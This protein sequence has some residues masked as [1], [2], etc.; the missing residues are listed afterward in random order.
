ML[1]AI[2]K[3]SAILGMAMG[4]SM[5]T[6]VEPAHAA[7]SKQSCGGLNQKTCI[8]VNPAKWCDAGL[9][10]LPKVGRDICIKPPPKPK[11]KP[12]D[13][14]GGLNQK[15]CINVNPAKWCNA[16]LVALPKLGR[17]ICG[18]APDK[19]P[20][21]AID[22]GCLLQ[23][24]CFSLNPAKWCDAGLTQLA[25]SGRNICIRKADLNPGS[26]KCGGLNQVRCE[27][28]NPAE[29]CDAGLKNKVV[30][31]QRDICVAANMRDGVACGGEGQI[32]CKN[33]NP[34]KWCDEGLKNKIVWGAPDICIKRVTNKDRIDVAKAVM[35]DLGSNN[36]L[37]KLTDCLKSPRKLADLKSAMDERSKNGVFRLIRACG[38]SVED[39][40][41]MGSLSTLNAG[42]DGTNDKFFKTIS[43]T[44]GGSGAAG[45]A[46]SGSTGIIIEL[47]QS[48]NAR[49]F[50]TG[51]VGGGP[52][53][54]IVGDITVGLSRSEIPTERIGL[55][56]G[57][58][59]VISGHY[60]VGLSGGVEFQGNS[61][62][63]DGI[64]F[65]AGGG[66][67]VGGAVY[68]T[69]AIFPFKDL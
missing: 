49:W 35:Q 54:E 28:I 64:S 32:R 52:K 36:P 65:G 6:P 25:K 50:F 38:T 60:I 67:G 7:I 40:K 2:I 27:S 9:V 23:N 18:K 53:A 3:A 39:L 61:L 55:D 56:H 45:V 29:W 1:N 21:T 4:A 26:A 15:T 47:Q 51:G 57:V 30:F 12:K 22:F 48:P 46:V 34:A 5:V 14:C 43:I 41:R 58:G 44:V 11:P 24:T 68:K 66:A 59:A 13:P 33:I 42:Q 17:D 16:G 20:P 19:D 63:F 10:V 31:G 37:A 69:G 62:D 8:N